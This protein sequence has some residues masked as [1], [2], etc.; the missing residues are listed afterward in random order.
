MRPPAAAETG[1]VFVETLVAV[2]I[3]AAMAGLWFD[4]LAQG[5]RQQR[6]LSDRRIAM[7]VV[8]S[9]MATVGVL[10]ADGSG[11]DRGSDAGMDWRISREPFPQAGQGIDRVTVSAGRSGEAA[12]ATLQSLRTGR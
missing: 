9:R 8:Q 10:T 11:D 3:V 2:L 4:T 12:L 5:A 1:A 7:L 6:A